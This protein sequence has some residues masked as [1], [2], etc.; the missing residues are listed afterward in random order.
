MKNDDWF[1][2]WFMFCVILGLIMV[3]GVAVGVVYLL[4]HV[5]GMMDRFGR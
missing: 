5:V 4:P 2:A 3:V 1:T